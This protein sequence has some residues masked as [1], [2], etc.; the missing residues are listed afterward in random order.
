MTMLDYYSM[1]I[2]ESKDFD[3]IVQKNGTV[4]GIE[5]D[6][7]HYTNNKLYEYQGNIFSVNSYH[8]IVD[9]R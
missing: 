4:V 1:T 6:K 2:A 9:I 3:K 8:G 7:E 5:W